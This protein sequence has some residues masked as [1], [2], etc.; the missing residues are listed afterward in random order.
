[1]HAMKVGDWIL[2]I[3]GDGC[4]LSFLIEVT[5]PV[6]ETLLILVVKSQSSIIKMSLLSTVFIC[7]GTVKQQNFTWDEFSLFSLMR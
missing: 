4:V 3:G 6:R 5:V 7:R 2:R 1:M